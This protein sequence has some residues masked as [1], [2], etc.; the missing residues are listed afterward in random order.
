MSWR[1]IGKSKLSHSEAHF[2]LLPKQSNISE[3]IIKWRYENVTHGGRGMTLNNL[4]QNGF[5]ILSAN[6]VVRGMIYKCAN[7]RKLFGKFGVQKMADLPKVR[8]FGVPPF[9]PCGT[10]VFGPYTI[11]ERRSDLK[12]YCALLTCFASRV[13]YIEVSNILDI[14]SF[15][16][17]F[18]RFIARR[19]PVRSIRSNNGTN[20]VGASNELWKVLD[21]I[22]HEQVKV[23][24]QKNGSNWIT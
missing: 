12:R 19:I 14:D 11:R 8:C 23:Y 5:W 9:T 17:A 22:I 18:R 10:D 15:S 20:F 3:A 2:M 4:R 16:Q 24:L 13:V 1:W 6:V 21:E 7:C